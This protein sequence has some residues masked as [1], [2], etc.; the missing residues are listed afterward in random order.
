MFKAKAT[1]NLNDRRVVSVMSRRVENKVRI[2]WREVRMAP[3]V[4]LT[5]QGKF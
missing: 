1:L 4:R 5:E 3:L 2:D